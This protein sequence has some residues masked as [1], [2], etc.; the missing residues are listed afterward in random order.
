M[1]QVARIGLATRT[2][3]RDLPDAE[4]G[5]DDICTLTSCVNSEEPALRVVWFPAG[6]GG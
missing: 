6:F 1:T 2:R 5:G 4:H 3:E